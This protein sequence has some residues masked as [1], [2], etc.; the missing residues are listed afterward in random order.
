MIDHVNAETRSW[1]QELEAEKPW[2]PGPNEVESVLESLSPKF[3]TF[4]EERVIPFLE[5]VCEATGKPYCYILS[6]ADRT[7]LFTAEVGYG[8]NHDVEVTL[9]ERGVLKTPQASVEFRDFSYLLDEEGEF[10]DSEEFP[11]SCT[12]YKMVQELLKS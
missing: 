8:I 6:R 2:T 3:R 7:L 4:V 11:G 10:F 5:A 1:A 9:Y 12:I